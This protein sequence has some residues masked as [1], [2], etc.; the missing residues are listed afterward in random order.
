MK[1]RKSYNQ[2]ENKKVNFPCECGGNITLVGNYWICNN[3]NF[4]RE[5]TNVCTR[6]RNST[7]KSDR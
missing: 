7:N 4:I 6:Y 3:C 2:L 5:D 1:K